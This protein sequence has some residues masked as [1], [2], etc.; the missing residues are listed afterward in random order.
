MPTQPLAA[1][2]G[3]TNSTSARRGNAHP[4]ETDR[5]A[6]PTTGRSLGVPDPEVPET[7]LRA[8]IR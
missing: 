4:I 5:D 6:V 2:N 3:R 7:T 1:R 8:V